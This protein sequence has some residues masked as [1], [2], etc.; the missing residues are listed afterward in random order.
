[1]LGAL[2]RFLGEWDAWI[3][4]VSATPAFE[5]RRPATKMPGEPIEVD[6]RKLPYWVAAISYTTV[7]NLTGN[8][9]VVLPVARSGEGLPIGVQVV[10]K[11]WEDMRL[12]GL[13]EK[14]AEVTGPFQRP[15]GY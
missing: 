4:A 2:E 3:C 9:V 12:L 14:L 1:M 11:K 10:G 7:F 8:P 13:A 6:G 15:P 5:H